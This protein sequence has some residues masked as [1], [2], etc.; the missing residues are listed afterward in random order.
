MQH[1]V[2]VAAHAMPVKIVVHASGATVVEVAV[3]AVRKTQMVRVMDQG[4]VAIIASYQ[5]MD[6]PHLLSAKPSQR[7][8]ADA[9]V[10]H[11]QKVIAGNMVANA[12]KIYSF[13]YYHYLFI[14][15]YLS[16][17]ITPKAGINT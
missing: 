7:K 1:V 11:D 10:M 9:V 5:L 8:A 6:H 12:I 2:Q 3:Y 4:Q 16:C 15:I 17:P 14:Q 13:N